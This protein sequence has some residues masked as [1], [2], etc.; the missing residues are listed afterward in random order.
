RA[1]P[2]ACA[3]A[4]A[5][6]QRSIVGRRPVIPHMV[7][8]GPSATDV[9]HLAGTPADWAAWREVELRY[10]T[11]PG[12]PPHATTP[13]GHRLRLRPPA[14]ARLDPGTAVVRHGATPGPR[15]A[16][17]RLRHR[18]PAARRAQQRG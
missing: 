10:R 3:P 12:G 7:V 6:P 11:Q 4:S 13:E 2:A 17:G 9:S 5:P 15:A 8:V 16:G 1:R 14:A 18:L